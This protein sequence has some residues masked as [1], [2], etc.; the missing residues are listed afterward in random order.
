M[1][2]INWGS[3]ADWVSGIGSLAAATVALYLARRNEGIR[4]QGYCGLRV[5]VGG[6]MAQHE[7]VFTSV[8][9]IGTRSTVI[10]LIGMRVGRF[11]KRQAVIT[12]TRDMNSVGTSY[13]LADGQQAH[14]G[15]PLDEEKKW[16][17]EACQGF[18][19]TP[20]DVRTLKIQIHTTHGYTLN[21]RPEEP[22]RKAMLALLAER[23]ENTTATRGAV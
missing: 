22:L 12:M 21:I 4:L 18:I 14:W 6:G 19:H 13:P 15:I 10:Q 16:L 23:Q 5:S 1:S 7:L 9:N 20:S 2:Q 11:K 8:T 3:V 17:R